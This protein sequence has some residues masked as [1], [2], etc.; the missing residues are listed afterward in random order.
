MVGDWRERKGKGNSI[1]LRLEW[2]QSYQDLILLSSYQNPLLNLRDANKYIQ[3]Q[4]HTRGQA[5][6]RKD[7]SGKRNRVKRGGLLIIHSS[8]H[9]IFNLRCILIPHRGETLI[10]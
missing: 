6:V 2:K 8:I 1:A 5:H 4:H 3:T 10:S 9:S 7:D